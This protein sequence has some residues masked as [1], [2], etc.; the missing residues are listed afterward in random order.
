MP[1]YKGATSQLIHVELYA[2]T[3]GGLPGLLYSDVTAHYVRAGGTLTVMIVVEQTELGTWDEDAVDDT[4]ALAAVDDAIAPG[5]YEL[6]LP[7][8]LLATGSD[9][10]TLFLNAPDMLDACVSLRLDDR[11]VRASSQ[12]VPPQRTYRG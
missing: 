2:L 3:G 1:I 12:F 8:N 5:L 10:A 4:L 7:N 6:S 9:Y 11:P